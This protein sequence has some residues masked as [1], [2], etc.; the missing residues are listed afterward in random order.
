[1]IEATGWGSILLGCLDPPGKAVRVLVKYPG[2][3][4]LE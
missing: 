1:M 3:P 2:R 4:L